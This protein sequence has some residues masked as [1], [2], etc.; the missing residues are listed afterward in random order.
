MANIIRRSGTDQPTTPLTTRGD[1]DPFR[2]MREILRWDPLAELM[3]RFE[4]HALFTPDFEVK[5]TPNAFVFKADLPGV[6]EKDLEIHVSGNRLTISGHRDAEERQ[7]GETWYAYERSYGTFTRTF[8]L[9]EGVDA[10][11]V[12]ADLQSG[13]LTVTV[14]KHPEA[15]PKRIAVKST[16]GVKAKS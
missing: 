9:P 10:D 8:T 2:M 16:P 15:Q 14:P 5:E 13:V 3:P 1:W 12:Q 7:E 4:R 6:E 11:H